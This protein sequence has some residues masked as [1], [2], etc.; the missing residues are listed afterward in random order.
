M[1]LQMIVRSKLAA[2]HS[3]QNR[4]TSKSDMRLS[5]MSR[6][7]ASFEFFVAFPFPDLTTQTRSVRTKASV[8][9]NLARKTT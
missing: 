5:R 4:T 6:Y 7:S 1:N 3:G 2:G 9:R 8:F